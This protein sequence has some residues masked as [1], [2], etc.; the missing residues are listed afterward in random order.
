MGGKKHKTPNG[1]LAS[2]IPLAPEQG[3]IDKY[4]E[5]L[6]P[7]GAHVQAGVIGGGDPSKISIPVDVVQE[8]GD[9]NTFEFFTPIIDQFCAL[10]NSAV[11][12]TPAEHVASASHERAYQTKM[13]DL[14][15][16]NRALYYVISDEGEMRTY[17]NGIDQKRAGKALFHASHGGS[18]GL[19]SL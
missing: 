2:L 19:F 3:L 6:I 11:Q 17:I 1:R 9:M 4:E 14:L 13:T 8:G 18:F 10:C 12:G 16:V 5:F 15:F 7:G